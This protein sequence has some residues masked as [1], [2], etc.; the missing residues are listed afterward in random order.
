MDTLLEKA[1]SLSSTATREDRLACMLRL[2]SSET[3][4]NWLKHA[5]HTAPARFAAG[6]QRDLDAARG[7]DAVVNET[8][9]RADQ[10]REDYQTA[11]IWTGQIRPFTGSGSL[12]RLGSR[13]HTFCERTD[14][15]PVSTRER[16]HGL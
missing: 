6:L 15:T 12:C 16:P 5:Q 8:S 9:G 14:F 2:R 10:P 3:L 11:D 1:L 7:D 4:D 13:H